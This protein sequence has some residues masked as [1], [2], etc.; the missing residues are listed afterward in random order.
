GRQLKELKTKKPQLLKY[1]V[2]WENNYDKTITA[3]EIWV[4]LLVVAVSILATS[5]AADLNFSG[6]PILFFVEKDLI[7]PAAAVI[8]TLI[9]GNI[10]P[11]TIARYNAQK[12]SEF[13]L[14]FVVRCA[15]AFKFAVTIIS[16]IA[17]ALV[18][19]ISRGRESTSVKADE[20]DFLLSNEITSPLPDYSR[21]IIS[22]IMD[23]SERKVFQVMTPRDDL[24]AVDINQSRESTIKKIIESQYSR[25]PVYN[26]HLSNVVGIIY[27]KDLAIAWN[28]SDI[29]ILQD[30]I[31][32][33]FFVPQQASISQILKEFKTG[34]HHCA[35]VVDEFGLTVGLVSIED[36]L[37][38][39]VGEVSDEYDANEED[40][41]AAYNR[42]GKKEYL[43]EAH[44]SILDLNEIMGADIPTGEFSTVSGWVLQL[45]GRIP[46][47]GEK[48]VWRNFEVEII[49]ADE[50]KVSRVLI[51]QGPVV[52]VK[53][54]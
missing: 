8:A 30:M 7:L 9:I 16:T 20:I 10:I 27:S 23:F 46:K 22:K 11:K 14:P 54:K 50:K 12:I 48:I 44:E 4:N 51:R 6:A 32:S 33:A 37:E 19:R 18:L 42:F 31:R 47:V 29:I 39:I 36:L 45:F 21:Q 3:I 49:V 38:E 41:V 40:H 1:A 25:V 53:S 52:S 43:V 24:F 13:V 28:N 5:I 26:G 34:H 17:T 35:I 2:F 15:K